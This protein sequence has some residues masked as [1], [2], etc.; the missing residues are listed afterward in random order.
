MSSALVSLGC[1]GG[2]WGNPATSVVATQNPLVAQYT[3]VARPGFTAWVEFGEDTNYGR[4]TSVTP[5]TMGVGETVNILV[6]G[7]KPSTT[8]HMRA[9]V[10][11]PGGSSVEPDRTFTTGPLPKVSAGTTT[12][13]T[14]PKITVSHPTPSLSPASGVELFNLIEVAG[15]GNWLREIVTDL[16]GNV[17]WYY[18]PGPSGQ[19]AAPMKLLQNGHFIL[20]LGPLIEVDLAGNTVRQISFEQI[21]QSLQT[22]GYKF[23]IIGFHHDLLPLQNDH[24][25]ALCNTTKDFTNL[26]GFPGVTHM[27]GDALVDIDPSGNVVWAWSAFDHLDVNRHPLGLADFQGAGAD[28]THGN[29][30]VSSADGNLFLSMRNQ[31]WILKI[32]YQNGQGTGDILWRL[33]YQGDFALSQDTLSDWF[34]AQHYPVPLSD[35]GSQTT[36][37]IWDNGDG[38]IDSDDLPCGISP[39]YSRATIFQIDQ[40]TKVANLM[41][42]YLPGFFSL[43]GGSIGVL[44]NGDIEF[45]QTIPFASSASRIQEVTH[46]DNPQT[47][48][49]LDLVGENAYRGYRIPSLYPGVTWK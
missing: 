3:I 30:I 32:D 33:G 24:W 7:M 34:Y 25:I 10:D 21:N 8:Y 20:N 43:W 23:S 13:L 29:A 6:A 36:F 46:T 49:Q 22:N 17:I 40:S 47:V 26:P 16:Q 48:W 19:S 5:P 31:S 1:G 14:L 42:Q 44:D 38:R 11:W 27:L 39:C 4:Q 35:D 18:D 2:G 41:W 45:D 12:P 37:A 28:W 15:S 9:H